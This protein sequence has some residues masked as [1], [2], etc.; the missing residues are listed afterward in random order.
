MKK[1]GTNNRLANFDTYQN[2][3]CFDAFQHDKIT[4]LKEF[5]M[6]ME[7]RAIWKNQEKVV[8][9]KTQQILPQKLVTFC[10]HSFLAT[11]LPRPDVF[12]MVANNDWMPLCCA[13]RINSLY[14]GRE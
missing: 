9:Q 11:Y 8:E 1:S 3:R 13:C 14:I 10:L 5:E 4:S 7:R 12:V 6:R 2:H